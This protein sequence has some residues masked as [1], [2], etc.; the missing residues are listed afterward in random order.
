M[1]EKKNK[2]LIIT[3]KVDKNDSVLGFFHSWILEFAKH[4]EELTVICLKKGEYDL[5]DNVRVMSLGKE[6]GISKLKYII[7]FYKYIWQNRKNYNNVFVHM[8]VEYVILGSLLWRILKKKVGLWYMHKSVTFKLKLAEKLSNVIFTGSKESFRLESKKLI[9]LHHGID[10][11]VFLKKTKEYSKELNLLTVSRISKV[12]NIDLM[13]DLVLFLK[14]K[15]KNINL[16]IIGDTITKSDIEYL[17]ILKKRV[18]DLNLENNVEFQGAVTN[19]NLPNFYQA[20][21]IL[22]NF[23]QTGSIDKVILEAMS[24]GTLVLTTNES[25][26]FLPEKCFYEHNDLDVLQDKILQLHQLDENKKQEL[27]YSL[28]AI[29]KKNHELSDLIKQILKNYEEASK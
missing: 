11:D 24:C 29:V 5:P 28:C 26:H 7:N 22:L 17:D 10:S 6:N 20:A 23:S 4:C 15:I 2:L 27:E 3:Q 1:D 19:N 14:D 8:N 13:V 16:K 12:K 18:I 21:D 25:M 9:V